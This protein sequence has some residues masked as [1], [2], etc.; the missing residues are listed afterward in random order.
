MS[1]D[2]K[3][4]ILGVNS[5]DADPSIELRPEMNFEYKSVQMIIASKSDIEIP[6]LINK[7]Q[8]SGLIDVQCNKSSGIISLVT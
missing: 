2:L 3:I 4:N 1:Q 6:E 5:F 7:L 8:T